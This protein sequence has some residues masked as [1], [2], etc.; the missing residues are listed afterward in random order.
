MS[1]YIGASV[2]GMDVP[3]NTVDELW[4]AIHDAWNDIPE[5]VVQRLVRSGRRRCVVVIDAADQPTKY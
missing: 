3:P 4:T 1:S 2:N 5:E